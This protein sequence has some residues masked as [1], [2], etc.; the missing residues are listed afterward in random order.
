MKMKKIIFGLLLFSMCSINAQAV[1]IQDLETGYDGGSWVVSENMDYWTATDLTTGNN[2]NSRFQIN[3]ENAGYES[4][5]GIY[6]INADGTFK[7]SY[8]LFDL[9]N[10]VG[11]TKRLAFWNDAGNWSVTTSFNYNSDD[12][13]DNWFSFSK[14]FGFF[15]GI[16]EGAN[17]SVDYTVFTDSKFNTGGQENIEHIKTGYE[18]NWSELY[19]FLDDQRHSGRDFD[20]TDMTVFVTDVAP[21]PEPATL[22]LLCSGLVGLA[23][24]K[25]RKV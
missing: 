17:G 12:T 14:S 15:Y 6:D 23:F 7:S 4:T 11:D 18:K 10:E 21:V 16:D 3:L 25:R 9:N 2:G 20:Y 13:D 8:T 24:L 19:V 5:F 1:T 22:L